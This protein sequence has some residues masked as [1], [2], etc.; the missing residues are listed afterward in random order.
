MGGKKLP[1]EKKYE[2]SLRKATNTPTWLKKRRRVINL[3]NDIRMGEE[4]GLQ[5]NVKPAPS[6]GLQQG[7]SPYTSPALM[8]P[9]PGEKI[10]LIYGPNPLLGHL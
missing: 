9:E 8:P 4:K 6:W 10:H 2:E 7:H 5:S 3:I 1:F